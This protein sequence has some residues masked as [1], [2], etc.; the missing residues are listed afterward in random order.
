MLLSKIIKKPAAVPRGFNI[1][2]SSSYHQDA[3]HD[4]YTA[5]PTYPPILD[6]RKEPRRARKNEERE[7]K[8]KNLPTIE[9]KMIELNMPR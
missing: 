1:Q 9:Q 2:L 4:E 7:E 3:A 5:T 8:M 6:I